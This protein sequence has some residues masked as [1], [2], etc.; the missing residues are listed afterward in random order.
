MKRSVQHSTNRNRKFRRWLLCFSAAALYTASDLYAQSIC[1]AIL[2]QGVFDYYEMQNEQNFDYVFKKLITMSKEDIEQ[3]VSNKTL[4]ASIPIP[5]AEGFLKMAFGTSDD[6]E[7]YRHLKEFYQNNTE[8]NIA[9]SEKTWLVSKVA[10]PNI[11]AAWEHCA[12]SQELS[13][14][15]TGDI[16]K[17]FSITLIYKP[18]TGNARSTVLSGVTLSSGLQKVDDNIFRTGRPIEQFNSYTQKFRRTDSNAATLVLNVRN[19]PNPLKI[20]LAR[21]DP[22][23]PRYETRW[24]SSDEQGN[25]YYV[26]YIPP[27][28]ENH[29]DGNCCGRRIDQEI[30]LASLG[31]TNA[32]IESVSYSCSGAFCGWCYNQNG[33]GGGYAGQILVSGDAQSFHWWRNYDG[34]AVNEVY[35][36]SLQRPRGVCIRNCPNAQ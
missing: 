8:M 16:K 32:R 35:K 24:F 29:H 14:E 5:F 15:V 22:P 27:Q 25:P 6:Q 34:R 31:V 9:Y 18:A 20:E 30:S 3:Q 1:D 7:K 23:L 2:R 10:N 21:I 19:F 26:N 28:V 36:V 33:S 12:V 13:L 11:A 17:D 4:D